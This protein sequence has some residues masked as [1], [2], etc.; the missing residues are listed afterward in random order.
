VGLLPSWV[1]EGRKQGKRPIPLLSTTKRKRGG[2][3]REG[4]VLPYDRRR[5]ASLLSLSCGRKASKCWG[6]TD[7]ELLALDKRRGRER[8][9]TVPVSLTPK[10]VTSSFRHGKIGSRRGETK[11]N[12]KGEGGKWAFAFHRG[13]EKMMGE[14]LNLL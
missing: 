14:K 10:G 3:R 6:R 13:E 12:S 5:R 7:A 9:G 8:R 4:G 1:C 2:K 11:S